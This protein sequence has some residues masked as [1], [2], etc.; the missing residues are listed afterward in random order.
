MAVGPYLATKHF[1]PK[2]QNGRQ[3]TV[4]NIS[5]EFGCVTPNERGGFLGYRMAK[6][7][8]NQ[9]TK[10]STDTKVIFLALEPGYIATRLTGW[11]GEDDMKTSVRE[12]V[13]ICR[14]R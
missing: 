10:T 5:S 4:A 8:L 2:L 6:A 11:K 12:M 7:A 13:D 9:Q 3:P 14:A 1:L